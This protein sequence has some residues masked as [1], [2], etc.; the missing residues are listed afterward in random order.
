MSQSAVNR[1]G[2]GGS[3]NFDVFFCLF[4]DLAE[5]CD[6]SSA[7]ADSGTSFSTAGS[8]T[9]FASDSIG[10]PSNKDE[11]LSVVMA[12]SASEEVACWE[13]VVDRPFWSPS[14]RFE[15]D[16]PAKGI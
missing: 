5:E 8:S 14:F 12:L 9:L 16:C 4:L 11:G 1:T 3:C 13:I 6:F 15:S 2:A 7:V 10:D